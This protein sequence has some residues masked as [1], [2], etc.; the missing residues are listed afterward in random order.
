MRRRELVQALSIAG[1]V[2]LAALHAP[3][4]AAGVVRQLYPGMSLPALLAASGEGDVIEVMPGTHLAQVGVVTQRVLTIRG[5]GTTRPVLN[6]NGVSAEGKAIL[7]V[8]GATDVRI[9]NLEFRGARVPDLNGAGIRFESGVLKVSNCAFFDN[10]MGI[11][12]SQEPNSV[13]EVRNSEFGWAANS[14]AVSSPYPP[15]LLYAGRIKQLFISGCRFHDGLAGHL[16]KSRAQETIVCYSLLVDGS[17]GKASYEVDLPEGGM[18]WLI[19]NVIGQS[20]L[21][22]NSNIVMYGEETSYL[23]R[24]GL[25]MA[26]NTIVNNRSA[27]TFVR[28]SPARLSAGLDARFVNNLLVGTG[29]VQTGTLAWP[30]SNKRTTAASLLAP[31]AFNFRLV[32]GSPLRGTGSAPGTG[33]GRSLAPT[34]EFLIPLG[35]RAITAPAAWSPG[36]FQ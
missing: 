29:D 4:R 11:L 36:A 16:L 24:H 26:N 1:A 10:E 15:H 21:T 6:A 20:A 33:G 28:V 23:S 17:A 14:P 32:T 18:A 27:G 34:A 8:R 35:T 19:G 2:P 9:E 5:V 22:Q 30:T 12:T 3:A 7:V 31:W 13:L 25:Y